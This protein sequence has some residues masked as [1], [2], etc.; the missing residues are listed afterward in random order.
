[1]FFVA[2]Y[3]SLYLMVEL[4]FQCNVPLCSGLLSTSYCIPS[5]VWNV[6]MFLFRWYFCQGIA[7]CIFHRVGKI[8][9]GKYIS[10]LS[11]FSFA[12]HAYCCNIC[13]LS[14]LL[15][16]SLFV[17]LTL[18][19]LSLHFMFISISIDSTINTYEYL[20]HLHICSIYIY[21]V[22]HIPYIIYHISCIM[23][24]ISDII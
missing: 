20:W 13:Q 16:L 4:L 9:V 6:W 8:W 19:S 1:M 17:I 24:H 23:Y 2:F 14:L 22:Y 15:P 5:L 18:L 10:L 3:Q 11:L 12:H 7:S 21:T